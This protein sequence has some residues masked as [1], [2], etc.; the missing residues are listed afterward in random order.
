MLRFL[1][2]SLIFVFKLFHFFFLYVLDVFELQG[3]VDVYEVRLQSD[4]FSNVYTYDAEISSVIIGDLTPSTTYEVR[5]TI[6]VHGGETISSDSHYVTTLDGG[7]PSGESHFV[8]ILKI[9]VIQS[10][11]RAL[12]R[13][14]YGAPMCR[15]CQPALVW[16]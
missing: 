15:H 10:D 3:G 2:I 16:N 4:I 7:K 8:R 14:D 1:F 11:I 9:S 6:V 12:L 5:V 13:I